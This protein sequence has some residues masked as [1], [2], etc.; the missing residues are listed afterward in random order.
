MCQICRDSNLNARE[1][2]EH[3]KGLIHQIINKMKPKRII[4][5][6]SRARNDYHKNSDIDLLIVGDYQKRFFDRIAQ[7][8]ELNTTPFDLEPLIY[9][10]DELNR[11][12]NRPFIK[13]ILL[14]GI[15]VYHE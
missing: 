14:T 1:D 10:N 2:S 13:H 11:M 3:L 9:N 7:V 12:K 6:G 4:L 5:F 8:L 15:D